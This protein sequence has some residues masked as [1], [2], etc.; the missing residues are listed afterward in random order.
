MAMI[1]EVLEIHWDW[2]L[3]LDPREMSN[4]ETSF[5]GDYHHHQQQQLLDFL[6]ENASEPQKIELLE[7][8]GE[9]MPL[10]TVIPTGSADEEVQFEISSSPETEGS[11]ARK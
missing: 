6:R 4:D 7:R 2:D 5:D 11:G 8:D 3:R 9:P 1:L 10:K